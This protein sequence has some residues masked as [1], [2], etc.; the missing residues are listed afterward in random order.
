MNGVV[1]LVS[2]ALVLA[3]AI[4]CGKIEIWVLPDKTKEWTEIIICR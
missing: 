1:K 2:A 4:Y 3:V